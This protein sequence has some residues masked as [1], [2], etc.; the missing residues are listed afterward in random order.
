M[1]QQYLVYSPIPSDSGT[2][3]L[4]GGLL[5]RREFMRRAAAVGISTATAAALL[6]GIVPTAVTAQE[7]PSPAPAE[8]GSLL[9]LIQRLDQE[10]VT[11]MAIGGQGIETNTEGHVLR[12][13]FDDE[14]TPTEVVEGIF[15]ELG[16][17][18]EPI[19]VSL[20]WVTD[21]NSLGEVAGEWA[22]AE[23]PVPIDTLLVG[24]PDPTQ[25]GLLPVQ[26]TPPIES[27]S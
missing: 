4:F 23:P 19:P 2:R 21:L 5:D 1:H 7:S 22:G 16:H 9:A 15:A 10:G 26:V 13:A 25:G 17:E 11:I 6:E 20:R 18:F 14:Q 27:A 12:L 24:Q 8:P 3:Q